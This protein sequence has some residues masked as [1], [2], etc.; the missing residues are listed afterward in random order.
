MSFDCTGDDLREGAH[1]DDRESKCDV[2]MKVAL[3]HDF[4][5]LHRGAQNQFSIVSAGKIGSVL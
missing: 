3:A 2:S 4:M 1:S 5:E